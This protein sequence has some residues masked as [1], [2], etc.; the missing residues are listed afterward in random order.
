MDI[1]TI[2]SQAS[3]QWESI[4]LS[5][6][7]TKLEKGKHSPCPVCGGKDRFRF[8]DQEGRGTWICNQ[9][10]GGKPKAGDGLTLLADIQGVD[11]VTAANEVAEYL[12]LATVTDKNVAPK[13]ISYNSN[14]SQ[15]EH[16]LI[17]KLNKAVLGVSDYFKGKG[18]SYPALMQ[19]N[20]VLIPLV[21]IDSKVTGIQ[22]ISPDGAKKYGAGHKK[23][24]SF[25]V[26]LSSQKKEDHLNFSG[27]LPD[28]TITNHNK[29]K[30]VK[31]SPQNLIKPNIQNQING[32]MPADVTLQNM[33]KPD[34]ENLLKLEVIICEGVATAVTTQLIFPDSLCIA[35]LDSGNLPTVAQSIRGKYPHSTIII[36]ADNDSH[37]EN[38]TG[39]E[40][41]I[42]AAGMINGFVSIP[43]TGNGTDW[44]DLFVSYLNNG[45]DEKEAINQIRAEFSDSIKKE[46]AEA[47]E[48]AD[49]T[50]LSNEEL[51]RLKA[52]NGTF[53]QVII[54]DGSQIYSK[55]NDPIS[56][57][58]VL[59]PEKPRAFIARY[60]HLPRIA[61]KNAAVAWDK[62]AGKNFKPDGV[63]FYPNM[64]KCPE[65]VLNL[66]DGF[67]I[68]PIEGDCSPYLNHIEQVIC[69]GDTL[70]SK[71]FISWLAHL[72][73]KPDEK[74][75]FAIVMI[76][77]QGAGKGTAVKPLLDILGA[78]G[79]YLNGIERITG[80][81][82]STI[83][84]KL[85]VFVDEVHI[86]R[87]RE[88]DALKSLISEPV[89][90]LE[91][92]GI[93]PIQLPNYARFIFASNRID[94][95]KAGIMERRYL[96]LE[97]S[98][99]FAQDKAYFDQL[100]CWL[101]NNGAAYLFHYL[102]NYD[103]SGFDPRRAVQ[104][105]ALKS[106]ILS[107]LTGVDG[108]IYDQLAS[109]N[110]FNYLA[111]FGRVR[112]SDLVRWYVDWQKELGSE[113]NTPKARRELGFIFSNVFQ[114]KKHGRAGRG[115][116]L[117]YELPDIE[118]MIQRFAGIR[119]RMKPE[120]LF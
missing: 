82:N 117:V 49:G 29:D 88:A 47:K 27:I 4:I 10:G 7:G 72:L 40:A 60:N 16:T 85:L 39:V 26:V 28:D 23:K 17:G 84:N 68:S 25:Y 37:L 52:M 6:A 93:D 114:V 111:N 31:V 35:A 62:W 80:R 24:G 86:N 51:E 13:S 55:R 3:G 36:A 61:R 79:V 112:A 95:I 64:S 57:L 56:G 34:T 113:A 15:K 14:P 97:A 100:W 106:L 87:T 92:K 71:C 33:I 21:N 53:T 101:G 67:A 18:L 22:T 110:P 44:N 109:D 8:D 12:R 48:L 77:D 43:P 63:G 11:T 74:P 1:R 103:I 30:L 116:G 54:S 108:F 90:S 38:N 20:A 50:Q 45:L 2:T 65:T 96:V 98:N 5:L 78:F 119:L 104:T 76:S 41:A 115:E 102:L 107:D 46:I 19:N 73:Q 83:A 58:P 69:S 81:F 75:N 105:N 91:Q 89:V 9:C 120:D 99:Q 59:K 94:A 66:F 42:K 70:A 118:T 32:E